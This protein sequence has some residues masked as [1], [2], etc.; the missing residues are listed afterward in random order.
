MLC[1][2]QPVH[3]Q[4]PYIVECRVD[5]RVDPLGGVS[6]MVEPGCGEQHRP[7]GD[8]GISLAERAVLYARA[9]DRRDQLQQLVEVGGDNGL[10]ALGQNPI[11]GEH[12]R[13]VDGSAAFDRHQRVD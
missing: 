10:G 5:T 7:G 2:A 6:R 9:D 3:Q 13:V 8:D 12:L 11:G 4:L 1:G